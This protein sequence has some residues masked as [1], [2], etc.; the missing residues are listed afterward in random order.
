MVARA[1]AIPLC[2]FAVDGSNRTLSRSFIDSTR[3]EMARQC[4]H[5][6]IKLAGWVSDSAPCM[7]KAALRHCR[8]KDG[9][10]TPQ[11]LLQHRLLQL[12]FYQASGSDVELILTMDPMHIDWRV[13]LYVIS[14][15]KCLQ[16][17]AFAINLVALHAIVKR[18][19]LD[20]GLLTSDMNSKDKQNHAAT[21][22]LFDLEAVSPEPGMQPRLQA[23]NRMRDALDEAGPEYWGTRLY[24]EFCHRFSRISKGGCLWTMPKTQLSA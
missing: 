14:A 2:M 1:P 9:E 23:V 18:N 10:Q 11:H 20:L 22:R 7:R 13:R 6:G 5:V 15:N 21:M 17:G 3:A 8:I 24:V 16:L 19:S 4:Q 12:K